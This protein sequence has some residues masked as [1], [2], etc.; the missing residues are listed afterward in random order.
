M[1]NSCWLPPDHGCV[2]LVGKLIAPRVF[3]RGCGCPSLRTCALWCGCR[4][5]QALPSLSAHPKF[6]PAVS[7]KWKVP[8]AWWI[9]PSNE[10][11]PG[12]R[13]PVFFVF[14][15]MLFTLA[16]KTFPRPWARVPLHRHET[17]FFLCGLESPK[18]FSNLEN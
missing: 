4:Y 15:Y 3:T 2:S 17:L 9:W 10:M 13:L 1:V 12:F 7:Y 18:W 6:I 11:C 8:L 5:T 14:V 16:S